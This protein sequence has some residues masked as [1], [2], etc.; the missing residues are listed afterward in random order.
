MFFLFK[1]FLLVSAIF[2]VTIRSPLYAVL[3]LVFTFCNASALLLYIGADFLAFVYI[4]VYIGAIAVLFLF[5][6]MMLNL[7]PEPF[8]EYFSL[9]STLYILVF[10]LFG[11]ELSL[12]LCSLYVFKMANSFSQ[13]IDLVDPM[14]S[15]KAIGI[16]LY[17]KAFLVVLL[18][19][20]ILLVAM[21]G[22]ILFSLHHAKG[23]RRQNVFEQ[24]SRGRSIVIVE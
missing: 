9:H 22:A 17:T 2:V 21:I 1:F 24:N 20:V 18:L 11:C 4:L 3:L 7:R 5:V 12:S 15:M 23:I 14:T 6:I 16:Y 19:G 8:S 13:I 10:I